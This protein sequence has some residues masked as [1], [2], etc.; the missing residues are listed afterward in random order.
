MKRTTLSRFLIEQQRTAGVLPGELRLLVEIVARACKA[1]SHSVGRGALGG[2]LG[3]LDSENV[4]G[5]VQK[6]LDVIAN[7]MLLDANEWGGHLAAMASEEM[8]TIHLIPNRFPKGEYLLLFDPI[9]GSSNID[10]GLSVGTIFSVLHAP[11]ESATREV[12]EADFLQHGHTQV[13]AGY[14]IYGPQTLL[15]LTVG[16]GVFEFT[17][18]REVGS[19]VM[20]DANI[21]MPAGKREFA[22]NMSNQRHWSPSMAAYVEACIAGASGPA[23]HDYNMRW[24]GSMVADVHRIL[25]RGG[26]FLYPA[27]SRT[28]QGKLRLMY[29]ANPMAFLIEQAGGAATDGSERLLD[30][31]PDALHQRVG[32]VLGD[33]GEVERVRELARMHR[34][35]S[36]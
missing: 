33:R 7:E 32:V 36:A 34:E 9:D 8:E 22:I 16:T 21:T 15:V 35:A 3:S 26:V 5:E 18:D 29:E 31:A 28:G 25:K 6:R 2:V 23:G 1:I 19:W 27:D 24:T 17:L 14:A 13:A 12:V 11:T 20:S 10:V 30:I 4:Q